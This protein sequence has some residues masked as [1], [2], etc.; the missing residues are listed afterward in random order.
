M[1]GENG[2][3]RVQGFADA[4]LD[5]RG[6]LRRSVREGA[7]DGPGDRFDELGVVAEVDAGE[8]LAEGDLVADRRRQEVGVGVTADIAKQGLVIDIAALMIVETRGLGEPHRADWNTEPRTCP[9]NES[10][11]SGLDAPEKG[12]WNNTPSLAEQRVGF[13]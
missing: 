12:P 13:C 2:N 7:G 4:P 11:H 3:A 5:R 8:I 10:H 6:E 9:S 1:A